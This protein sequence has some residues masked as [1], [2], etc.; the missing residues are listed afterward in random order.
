MEPWTYESSMK[1]SFCSLQNELFVLVTDQG[2]L[3]EPNVVWE[4]LSNVEGDGHFVDANFRT[5]RRPSCTDVGSAAVTQAVAFPSPPV[6][7]KEQIDH[8]SVYLYS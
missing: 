2:F 7:S 5:Y 3:S 4:T 8:E 6:N 1:T